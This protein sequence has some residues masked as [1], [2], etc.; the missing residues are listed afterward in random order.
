MPKT[1]FFVDVDGVLNVGMAQSSKS[2][3]ILS[4]H[5]LILAQRLMMDPDQEQ[6]AKEAAEAMLCVAG[7]PLDGEPGCLQKYACS[8]SS[9]SD[10]LVERLAKLI[11]AAGDCHVVL[12]SSW[13][14]ERYR[15]RR[16][17]LERKLG[18]F[19]GCMFS[20]HDVTRTDREERT[21]EERLERIGDYLEE[22]CQ[23]HAA[24]EQSVRVV[25]LD[26]FLL[27]PIR[28]FC[29]DQR[30]HCLDDLNQYLAERAGMHGVEAQ[31]KTV[32]PY[33]E[34][35]LSTGKMRISI[36]IQPTMFFEVLK[37]FDDTA[38]SSRLTSHQFADAGALMELTIS[39]PSPV[40]CACRPVILAL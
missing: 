27:S 31:V 5:N 3:L 10:L 12:S 11:L 14:H 2:T 26:D 29:G 32:H 7:H 22:Y 8:A 13:R 37:F 30:I 36:G 21:P 17:L 33:C 1:L 18:K 34:T 24:S 9:L 20:F 28:W 16:V 4:Q 6:K 35:M 25:V 19:L 40:I 23:K 39:R 15:G 38:N